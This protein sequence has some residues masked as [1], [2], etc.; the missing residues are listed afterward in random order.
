MY[1]NGSHIHNL[2]SLCTAIPHRI[3]RIR[4]IGMAA[5]VI[6]NSAEFRWRTMMSS[7]SVSMKPHKHHSKVSFK[8]QAH[9]HGYATEKEKVELEQTDHD[10][11]PLIHGCGGQ[12]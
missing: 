7:F 10:L 8:L 9:L 12:L 4:T 1:E 6:P 5:T 2:I 3:R 11:I